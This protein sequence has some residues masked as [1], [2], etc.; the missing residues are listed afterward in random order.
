M[1][2]VEEV[3]HPEYSNHIQSMMKTY[4]N[5]DDH[6]DVTL[7]CADGHLV[8]ANKWVLSSYSSILQNLFTDPTFQTQFCVL[9][10]QTNEHT[11]VI[12]KDLQER[13]VHMLLEFMYVGKVAIDSVNVGQLLE[14]AEMLDIKYLATALNAFNKMELKEDACN[15]TNFSFASDI[16]D[17]LKIMEEEYIAEVKPIKH[18]QKTCQEC[19][20]NVVN[21]TKHKRLHLLENWSCKECDAKFTIK[22]SLKRHVDYVHGGIRIICDH[23]P[24]TAQEKR[25]IQRHVLKKHPDLSH[26][27]LKLKKII[28]Q[29]PKKTKHSGHSA[30]VENF[31][32]LLGK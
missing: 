20:K 27:E 19:G 7:V 28:V 10:K 23:C 32:A 17:E 26:I 5:S 3:I 9:K 4:L 14:V 12:L 13:Y 25:Y 18:E 22:D 2:I 8:S 16:D 29:I 31:K 30:I 6:R 24:Y 21:L 15:E 11:I 1:D